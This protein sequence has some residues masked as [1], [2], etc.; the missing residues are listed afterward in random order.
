[1]PL[2]SPDWQFSNVSVGGAA[3]ITIGNGLSHVLTHLEAEILD[4]GTG[5]IFNPTVNVFDN[6]AVIWSR[7]MMETTPAGASSQ[8]GFSVDI[9]IIGSPGSTM[10]V[11]FNVGRVGIETQLFISG[12][13]E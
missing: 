4:T 3:T 1:M 6:A 10:T 11:A 12:H 7:F 2:L 5:V 8:V 13:D 9:P